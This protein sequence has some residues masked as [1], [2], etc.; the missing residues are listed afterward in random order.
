MRKPALWNTGSPAFAGDDGMDSRGRRK[1][2]E[3][4]RR[5][6][7]RLPER[8]RMLCEHNCKTVIARLDRATQYSRALMSCNAPN[9]RSGILDHPRS[10]VMTA[11]IR[12]DD[13]MESK[14]FAGGDG[15][16]PEEG[17]NEI[18]RRSRH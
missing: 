2:I 4:I 13:E 11:W 16:C 7:W 12:G 9:Q 18:L 1:W 6:R 17:A 15:A 8:R 5:R 10:R 3:G 14:E